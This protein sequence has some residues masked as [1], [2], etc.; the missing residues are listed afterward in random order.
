MCG[1]SSWRA[2][3]HCTEKPIAGALR[4]W[5]CHCAAV[6]D[7][8]ALRAPQCCSEVLAVLWV[9][10]HGLLAAAAGLHVAPQRL[11][12]AGAGAAG[13]RGAGTG[14]EW[15]RRRWGWGLQAAGCGLGG[16]G[17]AGWGAAGL[18]AGEGVRLKGMQCCSSICCSTRPASCSPARAPTPARHLPRCCSEV[19]AVLL[20]GCIGVGA[21]GKSLSCNLCR[22][23][24]S[25]TQTLS[26][27]FSAGSSHQQP[28]LPVPLASPPPA[29]RAPPAPGSTP[30]RVRPPAAAG[31]AVLSSAS[32]RPAG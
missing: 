8:L 12:H 23:D 27:S 13:R 31:A 18:R 7:S 4:G 24:R 20:A 16:C 28:C 9:G 32:C 26:Y 19:L 6:F 1:Y 14:G 21:G 25:D 2:W 29:R 10:C 5:R 15:R 17:A 30:P 22:Q 3:Y 11:G